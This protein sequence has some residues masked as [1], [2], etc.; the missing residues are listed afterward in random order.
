MKAADARSKPA[1]RNELAA[2]LAALPPER[3]RA[4]AERVA[5]RLLA[6]PEL[7][8]ARRIF[9]CLSFGDELDTWGLTERFCAEGRELF[10]PRADPRD[11]QLHVHRYPCALETLAFG[12]RQPAR[13]LPE[14][15]P[16]RVDAT[17]DVALVLGL[18]FDRRGYRL[19]HGS[20]YFDRF[21]AAHRLLTVGLAYDLQLVDALPIEAHDVPMRLVV[22]E[23][24]VVRPA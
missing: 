22:T 18:A 15:E 11:R 21:L 17:L 2:R 24:E 13:D 5:E 8:R 9:T 7:V 16:E 20:G 19:G 10:V 23:S 4:G 12:L 1:L 14:L 3:G 6:L